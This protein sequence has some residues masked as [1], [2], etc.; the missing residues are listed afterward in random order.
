MVVNSL[1][2]QRNTFS[3]IQK[4]TYDE[5][6]DYVSGATG[7]DKVTENASENQ[8]KTFYRLDGT[9]V[10]NQ[11]NS[12]EKGVYIVKEGDKTYKVAK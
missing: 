9:K 4:V 3:P 6:V 11:L 1:D 7:I 8:N 12:G 5:Y 2:A 10:G